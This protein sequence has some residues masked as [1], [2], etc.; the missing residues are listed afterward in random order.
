MATRE[1]NIKKINTELDKMTEEELDKVAGGTL[2]EYNELV[3][4]V[5]KDSST[6]SRICANRIAGNSDL[7]SKSVVEDFLEKKLWISADI[8][9]GVFGTGLFS[10]ANTYKDLRNGG[11]SLT[12]AEVISRI[13][14]YTS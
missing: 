12:H 9:V 5:S 4:A 6:Y 2:T 1:E 3:R 10:S 7:A 11:K 13:N 14:A 8:S